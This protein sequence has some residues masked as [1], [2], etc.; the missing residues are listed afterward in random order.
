MRRTLVL[1]LSIFL[2]SSACASGNLQK[3]LDDARIKNKVSAMQMTIIRTDQ[4]PLTL[5]SGHTMNTANAPAITAATL[6]QIGSETKSFTAA[7]LLKLELE[8]KLKLSDSLGQYFPQYKQWNQVTLSQLLHNNSGIPSYSENKSFQ[9]EIFK[10]R[11]YI[12][13]PAELIA[14]SAKLPDDFSPGHGWHYSNSNYILAG[15]VAEKVTHQSLNDLY[16][17]YFLDKSALNLNHTFYLTGAYSNDFIKLMAHGYDENNR[18]ITNDNMSWG[19]AAGAMVSNSN[20]L[21]MWAYS[22][23][24]GKV[25]P[26]NAQKQMMSVVSTKTGLADSAAKE[27]YGLGIGMR[28]DKKYGK[29]WGHEGETL[30]YHAIFVWFPAYDLTVAILSNGTAPE[31]HDFALSLPGLLGLKPKK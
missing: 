27:G 7:L 20:D 30:G 29:W 10:N 22:L 15:M 1:F 25:L 12:W 9:N 4:A 21:A 28:T 5:M 8:G 3:A 19:G 18:D 23:F 24:H 26:E 16:Q 31:L 11:K 2:A 17:H 14:I 13:Q 6:F